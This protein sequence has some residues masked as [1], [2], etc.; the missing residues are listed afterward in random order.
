MIQCPKCQEDVLYGCPLSGWY[1]CT[2]NN[3]GV[4]FDKEGK[5]ITGEEVI[6]P[7]VVKPCC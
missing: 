6:K 2:R 5:V 3:C 7:K 4:V 1:R